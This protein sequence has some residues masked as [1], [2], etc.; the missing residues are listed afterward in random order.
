M[1]REE[2]NELHR[3][4]WPA[5]PSPPVT[6]PRLHYKPIH[7][8]N[9]NDRFF[10]TAA[11]PKRGLTASSTASV[12]GATGGSQ[13]STT[14]ATAAAQ[15][16]TSTGVTPGPAP[17]QTGGGRYVPP[18]MRNATPNSA[19]AACIPGLM[20]APASAPSSAVASSAS[21]QH[22]GKKGGKKKSAAAAS[23]AAENVPSS[24]AAGSTT[25]HA[26]FQLPSHLRPA[27]SATGLSVQVQLLDNDLQPEQQT[28]DKSQKKRYN[29]SKV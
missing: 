21:P 6:A 19:L 29:K 22:A 26:D 23:A 8:Q 18:H 20:P 9:L 27:G 12:S 28:E 24:A 1:F 2:Y 14:E 25:M 10:V 5:S 17:P 4:E 15:P 11:P 3:L 7:P 16:A 13:G